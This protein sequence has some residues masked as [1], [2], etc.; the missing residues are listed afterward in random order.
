MINLGLSWALK[1]LLG[2]PGLVLAS[3]VAVVVQTLLMQRLLARRLPSMSFGRLWS[4]IG[5]VLIATLGMAG[6]VL[7]GAWASRSTL[8]NSRTVD[9]ALIFGLIPISMMVYGMI[10]WGLKVE[11]RDELTVVYR[12]L[13]KRLGLVE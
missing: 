1:D 7:V 5:K 11:G 3:T 13:L 9:L 12:K 6:V 4:T 8:P 10:L 2:A